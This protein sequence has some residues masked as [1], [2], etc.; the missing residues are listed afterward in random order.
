MLWPDQGEHHEGN[1]QNYAPD[2]D[3]NE[4][5]FKRCHSYGNPSAP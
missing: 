4:C 5:A 1:E 3:G 2:H